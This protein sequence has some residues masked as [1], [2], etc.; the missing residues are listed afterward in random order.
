MSWDGGTVGY[1]VYIRSFADSTGDGIGDLQGLLDR[2]DHLAWLGVDV[3][4]ITPFYPSP[5][6]D[7]GYDVADYTDI[8]PT[9]GTLADADAVIAKAHDLGIRVLIDLVPNHTSSD[10][11]WFVSARS[12]RTSPHRDWYLWHDG[13]GPDQPP[14]NWAS[15]FG[16]RAW[17][18]DEATAQWWC[19]LFLPEQPDLNWRTPAVADAFDDI[20]RFWFARGVDGFRIDVAHALVKHPDLLDNPLAE[21]AREE[22]G[23]V[24]VPEHRHL[25]HVHDVD[26]P[27]VLEVYRRWRPLADAHGGVLLGEVYLLEPE[28]LTRYVADQD[29][30]HLA[31]DFGLLHCEW[32]ADAMR[33]VLVAGVE[34][35]GDHAAWVQGSHDRM[36]AASRYGG[37]ARGRQR[38]LAL[39]TL[40]LGLPGLPFV[41]QGEELGLDDGAVPADAAQ[42]PVVVRAG[43]LGNS[44]DGCRTPIPWEPGPGWGFTAGADAWLPM[45]ER[46]DADT[47]AVQRADPTSMLHRYRALIAARR[48]GPD[49]RT[50]PVEWLTGTGPLIAYRRGGTVV[51]ANCGDE[52]GATL[53]LP[54]GDWVTTFAST[55][56]R[57][58]TIERTATVLAATEAVI[59][60]QH[61]V[62]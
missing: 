21:D 17:T 1:Q 45:G 26:Q 25:R 43:D 52:P 44:R 24:E 40:L 28:R 18:W 48:A 15:H 61:A 6:R 2:L 20:L 3:L 37:G 42:D 12:S 9:F 59:L 57:E 14:N 29:G 47:V 19:H 53:P 36:R 22:E 60:E 32:D 23:P 50:A 51:A 8:D 38:S 7:H 35:L 41:Y 62:S 56:A 16:G 31:F 49:L 11:P 27:E 55:A 46:T 30:L 58:G 39:A 4:W 33:D 54:P 34:A 5:M 10:H 13:Q